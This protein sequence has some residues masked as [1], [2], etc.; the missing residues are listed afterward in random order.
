MSSLFKVAICQTTSVDS[1]EKNLSSMIQQMTE[2]LKKDP[3]VRLILFPENVLY[4]RIREGEAI[5]GIALDSVYFKKLAQ[6]SLTNKVNIH[7]GSV[8][9]L[10]DGKLYNS[11]VLI[12]EQAKIESTYQKIH[13][14]DIQLSGQ[15]PIRESD[16]F[17]FGKK[18]ETFEIDGWKFGQSIC[19]DIRFSELYSEYAKQKVDA[20][21]IPAA[22][23]TKTGEAHWEV[24]NRA[25]AIENQSYV[26][27]SAQGGVHKSESGQRETF[28]HSIAVDPWGRILQVLSR[29]V[30]YFIVEL[31]KELIKEVRTQI[32]MEKHRRLSLESLN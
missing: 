13:L 27:S 23:L 32:P 21:L 10:I 25:R 22:F 28:G 17:A 2:V 16:V 20:I 14:F 26:L 1:V 29:D 7:L 15:A 9:L 19:Y 5:E 24:L 12:T 31:K 6:F 3:S 8:P 11:S 18:P 30:D 4:M